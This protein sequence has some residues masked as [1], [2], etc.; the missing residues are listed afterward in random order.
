MRYWVIDKCVY[1][2]YNAQYI[3][4]E[5]GPVYRWASV[6]E[7]V[8]GTLQPSTMCDVHFYGMSSPSVGM[9]DNPGSQ[10]LYW[11]IEGPLRC[12]QQFI[13]GA[14]QSIAITVSITLAITFVPQSTSTASSYEIFATFHLNRDLIFTIYFLLSCFICIALYMK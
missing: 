12:S 14:N 11:N 4:A 13:P 8:S 9:I 2:N 10:H 6:P 3:G 5:Y 7:Q 1:C